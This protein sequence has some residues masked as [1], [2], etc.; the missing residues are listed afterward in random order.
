MK[1][2][3]NADYGITQQKF[4][5]L[6]NFRQNTQQYF[7]QNLNSVQDENK[8][9][10]NIF[11]PNKLEFSLKEST[12]SLQTNINTAIFSNVTSETRELIGHYNNNELQNNVD[13]QIEQNNNIENRV[14]DHENNHSQNLQQNNNIIILD[15]NNPEEGLVLIRR[16]QA[17]LN[18]LVKNRY[19][20]SL[21]IFLFL[22]ILFFLLAMIIKFSIS[23]F[24]L[25]AYLLF[26][27]IFGIIMN[28]RTLHTEEL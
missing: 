8:Q 13:N 6:N 19:A 1:D 28:L 2:G 26:I 7:N 14:L 9:D 15:E 16:Q 4:N 3:F 10:I 22:M 12:E 18:H 11:R 17:A 5:F 20:S 24:F 25:L 21:Y 27:E 23:Y